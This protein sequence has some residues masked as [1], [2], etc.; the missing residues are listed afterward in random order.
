VC[1]ILYNED[2]TQFVIRRKN[3]KD[4]VNDHNQISAFTSKC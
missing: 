3:M 4:V 1:H 2:F